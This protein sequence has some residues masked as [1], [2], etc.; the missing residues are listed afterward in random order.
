MRQDRVEMSERRGAR[1][2][3][4]LGVLW[5][6]DGLLQLQP[7]MLGPGFFG[8]LIGMANMGLPHPV[9]SLDFRLTA[10]LSAHPLPWDVLFAVTQLAIGGGIVARRTRRLALAAS[11][12]WGLAVW[13]VGEGFGGLFMPG[14]SM[15]NGAPGPVLLYVVAAVLLLSAGSRSAGG[16][17]R[18]GS[19]APLAWAVL[20]IGTALLELAPANHAPAVPAA[21]IGDGAGGQPPP[22]GAFDHLLATAIGRHGLGFALVAAGVQTAVGVLA[23]RAASRR[24]ALVAGGAVATVYW[25]AGQGMGGLF[26]G[27]ATD[28][29]AGPLWVL[30]A[31]TMWWSTSADDLSRTPAIRGLRRGLSGAVAHMTVRSMPC[32]AA[33]DEELHTDAQGSPGRGGGAQSGGLRPSSLQEAEH[34]PGG[35]ILRTSIFGGRPARSRARGPNGRSGTGFDRPPAARSVALRPGGRP[36]T[37]RRRQER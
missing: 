34:A 12:P 7:Y 31:V 33:P 2:C 24:P 9:E 37:D 28:P 3:T 8:D 19:R 27:R 5:F 10:V 14:T 23:L 32:C 15:L 36:V 35:D 13:V 4:V 25:L 17:P 30:L 21:E 29:G 26:T 18:R 16:D 11:V 1:L 20:W 6:L 22:L